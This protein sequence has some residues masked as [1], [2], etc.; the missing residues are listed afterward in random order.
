MSTGYPLPPDAF[1]A[2][3]FA[4]NK[5]LRANQGRAAILQEFITLY[6]DFWGVSEPGRGSRHTSAEMQQII[7]IMP[8][9]TALQMLKDSNALRDFIVAVEPNVIPV[10]YLDTAFESTVTNS[11]I[12]IGNLRA[13]WQ[14][15]SEGVT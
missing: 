12:V 2:G 5:V 3:E 1:N 11:T 13:A 7:N 9:A 15:V 10:A 14:T 8:Q 4:R 6:N